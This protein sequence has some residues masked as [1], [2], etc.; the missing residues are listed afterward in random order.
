MK[1]SYLVLF[2]FIILI[3]G[4][5][6]YKEYPFPYDNNNTIDKRLIGTWKINIEKTDFK[7]FFDGS[8]PKNDEDLI[9]TFIPN[10][11]NTI[12]DM[13]LSSPPIYK[14]YT[15]KLKKYNYLNFAVETNLN[16]NNHYK[17]TINDDELVLYMLNPKILTEDIKNKKLW[18]DVSKNGVLPITD[19][20]VFE[21]KES[22]KKYLLENDERLY[23]LPLYLTR[24]KKVE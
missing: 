20:Y 22:Y 19:I 15:S 23:N 14:A 2:A 11:T 12:F 9:I 3:N 4:C 8:K 18:G 6:K 10:K 5:V 7:N 24:E 13:S 21:E 16:E 17:Y 1:S